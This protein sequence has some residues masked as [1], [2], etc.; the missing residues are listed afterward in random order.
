MSLVPIDSHALQTVTGG[1]GSQID[2]LLGTLGSLTGT[3][4]DI[5]NKTNGLDQ[6]SMLLLCVL[7]MQRNQ[8][9]VY[10]GGARPGCWW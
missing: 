1:R 9:V 6:G 2:S 10:V 4:N 3:I 7:A 8:G 5:K